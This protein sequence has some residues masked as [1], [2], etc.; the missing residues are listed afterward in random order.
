[1]RSRSASNE[2]VECVKK[3]LSAPSS[4]LAPMLGTHGY[5][6]PAL[7]GFEWHK[8]TPETSIPNVILKG[9]LSSSNWL[10][11]AEDHKFTNPITINSHGPT[12]NNVIVV[13]KNSAIHGSFQ[14]FGSGNLC[15]FGENITQQS[16][17]S[18]WIWGNDGLIFWGS[19]TTSNGTTINIQ[20]DGSRIIIGDDCMFAKNVNIRNCDMHAIVDMKSGKWTNPPA[21]VH[22]EPHVWL[23]EDAIVMKGITLGSGSTVG[24]RSILTSSIPRNTVA[25]GT[26]AKVVRF[27]TTWFREM[28]PKPNSL[29]NL[30]TF[31]KLLEP[32]LG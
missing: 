24:Q 7:E 6:M 28:K 12:K 31:Q 26:P 13:G 17:A 11:I 21:D 19:G 2:L 30:M 1:M 29:E 9:N 14:L 3:S 5:T 27:H 20:D 10:V 15:I 18:C 23:A 22:L 8:L 32:E 4:N 16:L 25:A